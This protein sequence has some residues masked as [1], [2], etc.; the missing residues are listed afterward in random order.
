VK[1]TGL[2][3]L[4]AC[5]CGLATAQ[6]LPL[7]QAE[8]IQPSYNSA[9]L[10]DGSVV[11]VWAEARIN[12]Y[13]I[14]AHR[15]DPSGMAL[16]PEP[17]PLVTRDGIDRSATITATSEGAF[18]L[19]WHTGFSSDGFMLQKFNSSGQ[20]LWDQ[21]SHTYPLG[22]A[23]TQGFHM[24]PNPQGGI[25]LLRSNFQS[26]YRLKAYSF[27]AAGAHLWSP[28]GIQLGLQSDTIYNSAVGD[29]SGGLI[30]CYNLTGGLGSQLTHLD[31]NGNVVGNDPMLAT[32]PF[33]SNSFSILRLSNGNYALYSY[34]SSAYTLSWQIMDPL[35]NL[36]MASPLSTNLYS[37][38][39]AP[40]L[41]AGTDGGFYISYLRSPQIYLLKISSSGSPVWQPWFK[42]FPANVGRNTL[43]SFLADSQN[44]P[45]IT[46]RDVTDNSNRSLLLTPDGLPVWPQ[47]GIAVNAASRDFY[48]PSTLCVDTGY[49]YFWKDKAGTS[50]FFQ[51]Q[52]LNGSAEAQL[53]PGGVV[54]SERLDGAANT[55][56]SQF[57][58]GS[59]FYTFWSDN[60][61]GKYELYMQKSD[62]NLN[63]LWEPGGRKF[64]A[65]LPGYKYA[66]EIMTSPEGQIAIL[67]LKTGDDPND[68][69]HYLQV[70]D[71]NG[72]PQYPGLGV[73]LMGSYYTGMGCH[74]G[75]E[76]GDY[77]VVWGNGGSYGGTIRGQR[78]HDAVSMWP[79]E[80]GAFGKILLQLDFGFSIQELANRFMMVRYSDSIP[81]DTCH[82]VFLLPNDQ[83]P[84]IDWPVDGLV[85]ISD[86]DSGTESVVAA[87]VVQDSLYVVLDGWE[88]DLVQKVGY[89]TELPWGLDGRITHMPADHYGCQDVRFE[90]DAIYL[91]YVKNG[92]F[93]DTDISLQKLDYEGVFDW[94]EDGRI[95]MEGGQNCY[96]GRLMT[97][98]N[99]SLGAVWSRAYNGFDDTRLE[100][101]VMDSLGNWVI[102]PQ[103]FEDGYM[104]QNY[105]H[106]AIFG[107][108][109]M[110]SWLDRRIGYDSGY[111]YPY[112]LYTRLVNLGPSDIDDPETPDLSEHPVLRQNYPNPF[113]PS[114]TIS[115]TLP[116][117]GAAD[118]SIYNL[119]GQLVKT[120]LHKQ[121]QAPGTH[122]VLWDGRDDKGSVVSSGIYLYRLS[123][124]GKAVSKRMVML[125]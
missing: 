67:Y 86:Y 106:V 30:V 22:S 50:Q 34:S 36:L 9:I 97:F 53:E 14:Y 103:V 49:W 89:G 40:K 108:R 24:L 13:D 60:R 77:Y 19:G 78:I 63:P 26:G 47:A 98:E 123:F 8:V 68:Y 117:A 120:L 4:L 10:T 51:R 1:F 56:K 104:T 110:V 109:A 76:A 74:L 28:D 113:N 119:K 54:I 125:K 43:F 48:L 82:R 87:Q 16:W 12:D 83:P 37:D 122:Q 64:L 95:V 116:Q 46:W 31:T 99:G 96:D 3:I 32:N 62:L 57:T 44:R 69:L 93:D 45:L 33:G 118:L 84:R 75:Y 5:C 21:A 91:L 41:A 72:N 85:Y 7:R 71:A 29:G 88:R 80:A 27:D 73:A 52:I 18:V 81:N 55:I 38:A 23:S 101:A 92:S 39:G 114:T 70:L 17:L 25:Y 11:T 2:I 121:W 90:D 100:Y 112:S 58:L 20:A 124:A 42:N 94:G 115:F 107:N 6:N 35:G 59:H 65:D 102:S 15:F 111:D 105:P 61:S 66:V 79:D